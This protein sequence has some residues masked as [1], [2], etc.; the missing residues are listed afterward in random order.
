MTHPNTDQGVTAEVTQADELAA[1]ELL[2]RHPGIGASDKAITQAFARHRTKA[3]AGLKRSNA[4]YQAAMSEEASR[5]L[6]ALGENATLRAA[7]QRIRD[8]LAEGQVGEAIHYIDR[9]FL[10]EQEKQNG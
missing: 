4:S 9:T 6:V 10:Q 3:V 2:R 7:I 8:L 5:H 1:F